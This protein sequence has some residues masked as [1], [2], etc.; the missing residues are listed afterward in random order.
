MTSRRC[1]PRDRIG[2]LTCV[3]LAVLCSGALTCCGGEV[4][5]Q[6]RRQ[7]GSGGLGQGS[8]DGG[9]VNQP[10][11]CHFLESDECE[12]SGCSAAFMRQLVKTDDGGLCEPRETWESSFLC[13]DP[14]DPLDPGCEG[15]LRIS[16]WENRQGEV[17]Q[18]TNDCGPRGYTRVYPERAACD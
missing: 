2:E 6:S 7:I 1:K 9:N 11:D 12:S 14:E 3:I 13:Y 16:Y 10:V 4:R 5:D 15:G 17:F 18:S 8:G